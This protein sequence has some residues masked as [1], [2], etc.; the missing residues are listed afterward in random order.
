MKFS[1]FGNLSSV[2]Q[3]HYIPESNI[4]KS[5]HNPPRRNGIYAFVYGYE[6]PFLLGGNGRTCKGYS[7]YL[8]N[9]NGEKLYTITN[10]S[11]VIETNFNHSILESDSL[12]KMWINGD[13]GSEPFEQKKERNYYKLY[14]SIT[15]ERPDGTFIT[16]Y[17]KPPKRK[18]FEYNGDIWHHINYKIKKH[19]I[20]DKNGSWIKT[21]IKT[22]EKAFNRYKMNNR[23]KD[24]EGNLIFNTSTKNGSKCMDVLEVFIEHLK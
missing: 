18:V 11:G 17:Y 8:K 22:F 10:D 23:L 3:A 1:R 7:N 4:E 5:F 9:S 16:Y 21:S 2:K 20:L 6:E 19:E 13:D 12:Y 15:S 24:T 14:G